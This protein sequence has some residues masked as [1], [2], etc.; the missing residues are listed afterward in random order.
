MDVSLIGVAVP[1]PE[2]QVYF[3]SR[4]FPAVTR[5]FPINDYTLTHYTSPP[6]R[7]II[8]SRENMDWRD[9]DASEDENGQD[10]QAN[11]RKRSSRGSYPELIPVFP[12]SNT[13]IQPACDQCR[14]TKSKCERPSGGA[15]QCKSCA[16]A[17]TREFRPAATA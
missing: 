8:I 6:S 7:V 10:Q 12:A 15:T 3:I 4:A 5:C 11:S 2:L 9:S 14:K 17:G 1:I 13:S 16:L